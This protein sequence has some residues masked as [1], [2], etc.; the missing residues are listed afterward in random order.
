MAFTALPE[1]STAGER[2]KAIQGIFEGWPK[3]G[4]VSASRQQHA[5]IAS[6][7]LA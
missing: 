1:V 4:F 6:V 7:I 5:P 2:S 3:E